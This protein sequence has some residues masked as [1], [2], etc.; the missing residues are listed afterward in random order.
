[1]PHYLTGERPGGETP[2]HWN[3]KV[4]AVVWLWRHGLRRIAVEVP[5]G[6]HIVDAVGWSDTEVVVIEAKGHRSDWT[7][8][9]RF[10]AE[11]EQA[12]AALPALAEAM[13]AAHAA[14]RALTGRARYDEDNPAHVADRAA[15]KAHRKAQEVGFGPGWR[16]FSEPRHGKFHDAE[17]LART[18]AR[19][20]I[21]PEGVVQAGEL[22]PGW[23]LLSPAPRI[24]TRS[25]GG[26]TGD[27]E[28]QTVRLSDHLAKRATY[29]LVNSLPIKFHGGRPQMV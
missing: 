17:L 18:S 26:G 8:E 2:E 28:A 16:Y 21:A 15:K 1:M 10:E 6:P 13:Q 5:F 9:I 4:A 29:H 25:T 22:T 20:V 27:V 23:G 19:Y 12:R 3:A 14:R 24:L 7:R 11:A